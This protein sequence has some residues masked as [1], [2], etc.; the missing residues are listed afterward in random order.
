M[1]LGTVITRKLC[2]GCDSPA[3][4]DIMAQRQRFEVYSS[5]ILYYFTVTA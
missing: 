3:A 1:V 4:V 2:E 5:W